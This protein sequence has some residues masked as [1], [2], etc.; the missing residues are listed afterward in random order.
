M[1]IA[2]DKYKMRKEVHLG[3]KTIDALQKIADKEKRS[4]KNLMEEI[5]NKAAK[6]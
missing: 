4:L 6:K 2:D 3:K 1:A 5:L